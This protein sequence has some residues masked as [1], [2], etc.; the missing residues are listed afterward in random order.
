MDTLAFSGADMIEHIPRYMRLLRDV[1][2]TAPETLTTLTRWRTKWILTFNP[3]CTR[4]LALTMTSP[5]WTANRAFASF[6]IVLSVFA[7]IACVVYG[8]RAVDIE[9][10]GHM[11]R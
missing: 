9:L 11:V 1:V 10:T 8:L 2:R 4:R 5:L 6:A 7:L 3:A